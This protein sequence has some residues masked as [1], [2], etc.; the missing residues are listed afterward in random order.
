MPHRPTQDTI[1]ALLIAFALATAP[2]M[3]RAP[4]GSPWHLRPMASEIG[5]RS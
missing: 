4:A 5:A 1:L 2:A 3:S